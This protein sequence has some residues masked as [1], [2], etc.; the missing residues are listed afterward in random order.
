MLYP[1]HASHARLTGSQGVSSELEWLETP[2]CYFRACLFAGIGDRLSCLDRCFRDAMYAMRACW[3]HHLP[4][5]RCLVLHTLS[6]IRY[7]VSISG[8]LEACSAAP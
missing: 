1:R 2:F 8:L 5:V 4:L 7:A 6:V 3:D